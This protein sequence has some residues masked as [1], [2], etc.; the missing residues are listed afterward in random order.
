MTQ[1]TERSKAG[2][3]TVQLFDHHIQQLGLLLIEEFKR[4]EAVQRESPLQTICFATITQNFHKLDLGTVSNILLETD[5]I[6]LDNF[7]F[8][9]SQYD[10]AKTFLMTGDYP[11]NIQI[12]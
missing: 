5:P 4:L 11:K 2:Y 7:K 3:I 1:A 6:Y 12:V 8:I 10:V 9:T